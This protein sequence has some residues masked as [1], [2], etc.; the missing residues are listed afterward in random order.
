MANPP[1]AT[2]TLLPDN[3]R[4]GWPTHSPIDVRLRHE[5]VVSLRCGTVSQEVNQLIDLVLLRGVTGQEALQISQTRWL[6]KT[7]NQ[8]VE[9]VLSGLL[10]LGENVVVDQQYVTLFGVAA[11]TSRCQR[12]ITFPCSVP[13]HYISAGIRAETTLYE[14]GAGTVES[15]CP[16]AIKEAAPKTDHQRS[17]KKSTTRDFV[18]TRL[19][20]GTLHARDEAGPDQSKTFQAAKTL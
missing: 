3:L 7:V 16:L 19:P 9:L 2:C 17:S 11:T 5:L 13:W 15:T 10:P 18:P 20:S 6:S 12:R 1:Q 4:E 8:C 14:V